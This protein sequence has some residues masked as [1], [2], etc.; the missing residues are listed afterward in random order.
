VW[1]RVR[2][3][4]AALISEQAARRLDVTIGTTVQVPTAQGHWPVEVV[5]I[6]S[7]YGNPKGQL[8]IS[9]DA[10][11][12][13]WPQVRQTSY[14]L[15]VA[16]EAVPGLMEALRAEFGAGVGRLLDQVSLKRLSTRVFERTFVVTAALNALTLGVAGI[17]LLTSLLA[18]SNLRLVQLAPLWA[19]GVPRYKLFQLEVLRTVALGLLTALLSLPLGLVVAWCL[20]AVVNVQ[21]FGWRLPLHL[22]PLQ[23]LQLLG[24]A[25]LI[26]LLA[27]ILPMIRLMRTSPAQLAKTFANER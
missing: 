16:P 7:D 27:S 3:G 6:Y 22:F 14:A 23:W 26:A 12:S 24:L 8:R 25:V 9:A 17:A 11:L 15:R 18:L 19:M 1:D 10:L 4:G 20:V 13:H 2:A 21:A 5:G